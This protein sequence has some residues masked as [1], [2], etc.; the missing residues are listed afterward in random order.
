MWY[1]QG[2]NSELNKPGECFGLLG[3][4]GAG[5]TTTFKMLTGEHGITS[6]NAFIDQIDLS[7]DRM[8][9]VFKLN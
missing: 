9:Q 5:K 4:N 6:G 7:T 2:Y 8:S 1:I 3:P